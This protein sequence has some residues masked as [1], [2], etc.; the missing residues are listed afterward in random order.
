MRNRSVDVLF[1][2]RPHFY[3]FEG[4]LDAVDAAKIFSAVLKQL[5]Q[6]LLKGSAA[7]HSAYLA[8]Q[9]HHPA[10]DHWSVKNS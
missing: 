10:E 3:A 6:L 4:K 8:E 7:G 2:L 9:C 5:A 1:E